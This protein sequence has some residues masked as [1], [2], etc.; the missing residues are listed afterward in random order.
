MKY[1][2]NHQRTIIPRR[3][4]TFFGNVSS[5]ELATGAPSQKVVNGILAVS[6]SDR[7]ARFDNCYDRRSKYRTGQVFLRIFYPRST[8]LLLHLVSGFYFIFHLSTHLLSVF[9]FIFYLYSVP[10][11]EHRLLTFNLE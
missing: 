10:S 1:T 6:P 9:Y 11:S 4:M 8:G 3:Q 2:D 5:G 7:S